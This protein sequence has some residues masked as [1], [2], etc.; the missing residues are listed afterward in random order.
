MVLQYVDTRPSRPYALKT[1][2]INGVGPLFV[3]IITSTPLE[4][5]STRCWTVAVFSHMSISE[6]RHCLARMPIIQS[7]LDF[8]SKVFSGVKIKALCRPLEALGTIR[9]SEENS[10]PLILYKA[11]HYR[12]RHFA[13]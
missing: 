6:V 7:V 4:R 9:S 13:Y 10:K 8:I 12:G 2:A 3:V 11:W 5:L 1:M